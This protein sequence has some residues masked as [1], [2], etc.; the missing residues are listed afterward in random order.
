MIPYDRAAIALEER[1]RLTIKAISG[2]TKLD[3]SEP[4]AQ[5]L[6]EVLRWAAGLDTEIHVSMHEDEI[7][8]PR[9]ETIEKFRR[10][11]EETGYRG[12]YAIPLVDDQGRL[13]MLSFDSA[14]PDFLTELH[15]EIIKLL[16]SQAT[17]ALRNASLYKEVPFI[18]IL[19]PLMEKKRAL[20]GYSTGGAER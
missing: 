15:I 20:P 2:V 7:S 18:G 19:E 3:T 14:D 17:L 11:F 16:S 12:F 4:S 1:N 8:D 10:Y 13:G 6:R 9:P 5:R